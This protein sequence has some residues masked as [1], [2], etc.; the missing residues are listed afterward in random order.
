MKQT[1]KKSDEKILHNHHIIPRH[2]GGTNDAANL[3]LLTIEEHAEAH[4]QLFEL[5]GRWQDSL[6]WKA[7]SGQVTHKE[8]TRIAQSNGDKSWMKTP[9]GKLALRNRWVNR[10]LHGTDI[11]WNK[12]LTKETNIILQQSSTHNKK[13]R[14]QNRL[15]NIGEIM[16]GKSFTTE[17]RQKLS[18]KAKCRAR[19]TCNYCGKIV[20]VNMFAR[21]HGDNC[22]KR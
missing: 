4:R 22:R 21:W 17:H 19:K 12:G 15:S 2:A 20:T 13:L 11:P 16:R 1:S 6:A 18:A 9:A 3:I 7:L 8:A 14:E 5:Y 10:R